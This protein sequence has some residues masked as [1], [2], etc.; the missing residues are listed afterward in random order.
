MSWSTYVFNESTLVLERVTLGEVVELVVE[1]LVDLAGGAV[2][3]EETT[4]DTETAHPEDLAI[5]VCISN[6]C[7]EARHRSKCLYTLRS[8]V[9]VIS[10]LRTLAYGRPQYPSSY[11]NHGVGQFVG[12]RSGL[13]HG[14][15]S[16]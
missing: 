5:D 13:G 3:D 9:A 2:L 1:V 10:C 4:E 16:A 7:P 6:Y 11:R 15:G 14:H 12:R 8:V